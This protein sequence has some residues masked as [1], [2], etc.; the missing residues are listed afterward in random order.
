MTITDDAAGRVNFNTAG[1]ATFTADNR[2]VFDSG[3]SWA[4][5]GVATT[6]AT[7]AATTAATA[8]ATTAAAVATTAGANA[9]TTAS[10]AAPGDSSSGSDA[11]SGTGTDSYGNGTGYVQGDP[12]VRIQLPGEQPICYDIEAEIMDYVSL[13]DDE[14]IDLEVNGRIEH[15]KGAGLGE[16]VIHCMSHCWQ[17]AK[18]LTRI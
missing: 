8:A 6:P 7:T 4:K 16:Y 15:I 17:Q 1:A 3:M 9:A 2:F 13:I 14:G 10:T 18:N 5:N 11:S 12:H